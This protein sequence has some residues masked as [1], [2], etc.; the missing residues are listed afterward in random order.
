M[1]WR[2]MTVGTHLTLLADAAYRGIENNQNKNQKGES[3]N[4]A[5]PK[6]TKFKTVKAHLQE[7]IELANF[8]LRIAGTHHLDV[9]GHQSIQRQTS[10][11]SH[12]VITYTHASQYCK[13]TLFLEAAMW[14]TL[15]SLD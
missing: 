5:Q 4:Q 6:H 10:R 12:P 7:P 1:T 14:A 13:D 8:L 9:T 2:S 11:P 15:T 3:Q